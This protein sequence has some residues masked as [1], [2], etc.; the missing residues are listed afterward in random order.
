M[1]FD[2][3]S[4]AVAVAFSPDERQLNIVA[5]SG[6]GLALQ[7]LAIS[8]ARIL[9]STPL[10]SAAVLRF[11]GDGSALALASENRIRL[12]DVTTGSERASATLPDVAEA[13]ALSP[14]AGHLVVATRGK[15]LQVWSGAPMHELASAPLLEPL[16]SDVGSLAIDPR[17]VIAVTRGEARRVG[18]PLSLQSWTLPAMAHAAARVGQ[19][20]G[21][22]AAKVCGLS[23]DGGRVAIN[24]GESGIRVRDTVS[25]QDVARLDDPGKSQRCTFSVDGRYLAVGT[26][27]IRIWDTE[28]QI[29]VA[30]LRASAA[31]RAMAFSPSGRYLAA[32]LDNGSV[33]LWLLRPEDLIQYACAHLPANIS[34][35]D[36][37]RYS[38]DMPYFRLCPRLEG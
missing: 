28:R 26:G 11:S 5:H 9:V 35:G 36:W 14:D 32:A 38:G 3:L 4:G 1:Q 25:G 20:R 22:F 15:M 23:E 21:G 19:D 17:Q 31:V 27:Y 12:V 24:A 8:D 6:D 10:G 33:G 18:E 37:E 7:R 30:Q 29:E 13:L 16:N 2:S 34:T